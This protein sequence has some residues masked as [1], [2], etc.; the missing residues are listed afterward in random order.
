MNIAFHL[1]PKLKVLWLSASSTALDALRLMKL[2]GRTRVPVLD[3]ESGVAGT[4]SARALTRFLRRGKHD[5]AS[6]ATPLMATPCLRPTVAVGIDAQL[7]DLVSRAVDAFVPVVD[8]RRVFIGV[9]PR[10][11]ILRHALRGA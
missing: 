9:V 10:K 6:A 11:A 5:A 8:D 3:A 7:E 1:V 4:V 2:H